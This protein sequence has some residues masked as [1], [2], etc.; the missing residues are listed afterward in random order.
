MLFTHR[1]RLAV[2]TVP[3]IPIA[4]GIAMILQ[5]EM[6]LLPFS[7][8]NFLVVLNQYAI[9][10]NGVGASTNVLTV[11]IQ[12]RCMYDDVV[13]LPAVSYTHLT[14]PTTTIV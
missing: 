8:A 11:V 10:Q 1:N 2:W 13:S 3:N 5:S 4:N 7:S 12:D 14:L 6:S 9:V